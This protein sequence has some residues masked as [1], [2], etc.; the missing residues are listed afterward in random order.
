MAENTCVKNENRP[1]LSDAGGPS[2]LGSRSLM[3]KQL[4]SSVELKAMDA[5][6]QST[7]NCV[8]PKKGKFFGRSMYPKI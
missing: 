7:L 8:S 6:T 3:Y 4:I 2:S 1:G 5:I